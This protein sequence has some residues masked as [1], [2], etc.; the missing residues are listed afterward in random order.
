MITL[1]KSDQRARL[2]VVAGMLATAWLAGCGSS[3]LSPDHESASMRVGASAMTATTLG[4]SIDIDAAV[5]DVAGAPI[6]NAEIHWELSAPGILEMTGNGHFRV[7]REGSVQIAAVWPR[8]PSVRGLVSVR[9]DASVLMSACISRSDQATS[10]Q[11][12]RCS[13]QRVVVR[14]AALAP[15]LA[16]S[17]EGVTR[18]VE[19][20]K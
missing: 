7:L 14:A 15:T 6:P 8:D 5:V 10:T 1:L 16:V 2:R 19:V 12:K 3:S 20:Q 9:V 18:V 11:P 13:Q 4:E 17:P